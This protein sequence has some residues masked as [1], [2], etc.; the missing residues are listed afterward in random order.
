MVEIII[1]VLGT[2]SDIDANQ[3]K[4]DTAKIMCKIIKI[5]LKGLNCFPLLM[6]VLNEIKLLACAKQKHHYSEFNLL[7]VNIVVDLCPDYS[8]TS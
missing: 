1:S 2:Y 7:F 6:Y 5:M 3:N 4:A 8:M